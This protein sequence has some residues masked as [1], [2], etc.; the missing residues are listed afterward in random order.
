MIQEKTHK[1]FNLKKTDKYSQKHI[2]SMSKD[3]SADENLKKFK[4]HKSYNTTNSKNH[5]KMPS[6]IINGTKDNKII[7]INLNILPR[8]KKNSY[9]RE[10]MTDIKPTS[11]KKIFNNAFSPNSTAHSQILKN[12]TN[13]VKKNSNDANKTNYSMNSNINANNIKNITNNNINN[14][15]PIMNKLLNDHS[16]QE[17]E[18]EENEI[19]NDKNINNK[20][21][22]N[23]NINNINVNIN[24]N[25][26]NT[27][28]KKN[29]LKI[30]EN[31]FSINT[32]NLNN[33][34]NTN[35]NLN[36]ELLIYSKKGYKEKVLEIISQDNLDINYQNEN[37]WTALHYAC[38]E[39]NLKIVEILIKAHS[40][41]NIKNNDKKTPLHI[42]VTRGY[43]D[44]T[45]LLV[46]NGGDLTAIDNEKNNIIHI[47]SIYGYNELLTY[48][49]NKNSSLVYSKNLFGSTPLNLA[50]KKETKSIIEK[51]MK[52][53]PPLTSRKKSK[54]A[55][56]H[57]NN[58]FNNHI[59]PNYLN[60][61]DPIS[62]IK[63]HKTN[64]NQIKAL[65]IPINKYNYKNIGN[66]ININNDKNKYNSKAKFE[67]IIK[68]NNK[69]NNSNNRYKNNENF[70]P[71]PSDNKINTNVKYNPKNANT[72]SSCKKKIIFNINLAENSNSLYTS[73][74]INIFH[75]NT[76]SQNKKN[77]KGQFNVTYN[78]P[79]KSKN[80]KDAFNKN[81]N[82]NI[83][84]NIKNNI[85]KKLN[86]IIKIEKNSNDKTLSN[87][88]AKKISN[89]SKSKFDINIKKNLLNN[90]SNFKSNI[91]INNSTNININNLK[92]KKS[93]PSNA[94]YLNQKQKS[95]LIQ[96]ESKTAL[97]N[98]NNILSNTISKSIN[99]NQNNAMHYLTSHRTISLPGFMENKSK[100]KDKN[101]N[102]NNAVIENNQSINNNINN[103]AIQNKNKSKNKKTKSDLTNEN[104]HKNNKN[105]ALK[106]KTNIN[107]NENVVTVNK[108]NK[109]MSA[110]KIANNKISLNNNSINNNNNLNNNVAF[111][112]NE[113]KLKLTEEKG[114][115]KIG[116]IYTDEEENNF[117][118]DLDEEEL[119]NNNIKNSN[120]TNTNILINDS[121]NTNILINDSNSVITNEKDK[122]KEKNKDKDK[123]KDKEKNSKKENQIKYNTNKASQRPSNKN[124]SSYFNINN[125]SSSYKK[126]TNT[127]NTGLD[128]TNSKIINNFDYNDNNENISNFSNNNN[129]NNNINN[130]D[131]HANIN[132]NNN[133]SK[134][135]NLHSSD[136]ENEYFNNV[137]ENSESNDY[138]SEDNNN[139]TNPK[140]KIG[141]SNFICLAL[142]GQ[143]SFGEVY[144]VQEKNTLN[145]YAMK[146]LDKKRIEKQNIFK[147][148]MT[149]RNVL[150][151][152]NFPFI[153]KLNYAFQTKEKLFL[154]LDYCPGGD[155]SKQLQ[156]Q[157]R[158]SEDKAKF[159]IC[160]ITLALGELHKKDI[161]FRDLKPDN[162]V[163]DKEG[164]AM[165]TDF[166]L[167]REGVNE[168]HIAKSFCGSIAYLA[169]EM[170]SR[171]GHGKAVDWYLL[172]VCFYEM[173]VGIPPYF[174]NNQEQIFKNIEK[175]EL[176]IPNFVSKKAQKFL[177]DLLKKDPV[178]RLGSKRDVEEIKEHPYMNGVDWDKVLKRQYIPPPIIQ[179][180]N[181]LNFFEQPKI[182]MD[183]NNKNGENNKNIGPNYK[184]EQGNIYEGWSFVMGPG[185]NTENENENK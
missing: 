116:Q 72:S 75:Y 151:I 52:I 171:T 149:E 89:K 99:N 46:E 175:A 29:N 28:K 124:D 20:N 26:N 114:S 108:F 115:F 32:Y 41:I 23:N 57:N 132:T 33:N 139:N 118:E 110:Y 35:N 63:I 182:F 153:V 24:Y 98:Q 79:I 27:P 96:K 136:I 155:L 1:L 37:G 117:I 38:D 157:T 127:N 148:A 73:K 47:C 152:I 168:K 160:E 87:S 113:Q 120:N 17:L 13:W 144:L 104:I 14:K 88:N 78:S 11:S 134:D 161:I 147:Y 10:K 4:S 93:K 165:L 59:N 95:K 2:Q 5:K 69:I 54:K 30:N 82:I 122:D 97:N 77:S 123:E 34:L 80:S 163:I 31:S 166:G 49:L 74:D 36:R 102:Q 19:I 185:K 101:I 158:F 129:N 105:S 83:N 51:F 22:A 53:N 60:S 48:L 39:G 131:N 177:R 40:N 121:N 183:N 62:K 71:S 150:S 173:L 156:I 15:K 154:L 137:D 64:Q 164:H 56:S 107:I 85:G 159:Y 6:T 125:T 184:N 76:A 126:N 65:M 21:K 67:N 179:K 135:N 181:Y 109:N 169:P 146:V 90:I 140:E 42:S 45:K 103:S 180:S 58:V 92:K 133:E 12:K 81:K 8:E 167:S 141:P 106:P 25:N 44:I 84:S 70:S 16:I 145:Y 18:T 66:L 68:I 142:L 174:S 119:T 55:M 91:N 178:N 7:S 43:F 176:F 130:K 111:D 138:D 3:L 94:N 170:L 100:N 50:K 172:G 162:I 128:D 143:G 112:Y 61:N 9:A 86:T